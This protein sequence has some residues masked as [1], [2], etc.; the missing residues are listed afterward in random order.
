MVDLIRW[1]FSCRLSDVA[2]LDSAGTRESEI[3]QKSYMGISQ[4][5]VFVLKEI[6]KTPCFRIQGLTYGPRLL[7]S[8]PL[9]SRLKL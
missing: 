7:H 1:E 9:Q 5:A 6:Y 3:R 4:P 2:D 8:S